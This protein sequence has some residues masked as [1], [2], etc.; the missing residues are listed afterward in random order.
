MPEQSMRAIEDREATLRTRRA[1]MSFPFS[2]MALAISILIAAYFYSGLKY[3]GVP[4]TYALI[5]FLPSVLI[6]IQIPLRIFWVTYSI[7]DGRAEIHKFP[8]VPESM[9][10][11]DTTL[12]RK[13]PLKAFFNFGTI[14]ITSMNGLSVQKWTNVTKVRSVYEALLRASKG[15]PLEDTGKPYEK[16]AW[17]VFP[18]LQMSLATLGVI[19]Q[20]QPTEFGAPFGVYLETQLRG[21]K[22]Q[23]SNSERIQ[24]IQRQIAG[25]HSEDNDR[26]QIRHRM[27][28][29]LCQ[30]LSESPLLDLTREEQDQI[31]NAEQQAQE[32]Y[33]NLISEKRLLT[34]Q[35]E[36]ESADEIAVRHA[37]PSNVVFTDKVLAIPTLPT[38]LINRIGLR[39]LGS[40][41]TAGQWVNRGDV[42]IPFVL[43]ESTIFKDMVLAE[44]R[45]PISGRVRY[46]GTDPVQRPTGN[47]NFDRLNS[48]CL[49]EIPENELGRIPSTMETTYGNLCDALWQHRKSILQLPQEESFSDETIRKML[50]D[51]RS[52]SPNVVSRT[53]AGTEAFALPGE[54][55]EITVAAE[56]VGPERRER[57]S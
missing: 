50:L 57:L 19:S 48:F 18:N 11:L 14:E 13:N 35:N 22:K 36:R 51:I 53:D 52:A 17:Q 49:I 38:E 34:T 25:M 26:M 7:R 31:E 8:G 54:N 12:K 4:S 47:A 28:R 24:Y 41:L 29:Y 20:D 42:I 1:W 55:V 40:R 43:K 33:L 21:M 5:S 39:D 16:K 15:Q 3:L 44:I 46:C 37:R 6:L 30:E 27:I 56:L 2:W 9:P 45:S 10:L 23:P 32:K